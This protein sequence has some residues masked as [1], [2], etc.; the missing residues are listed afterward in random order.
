MCRSA[1]TKNSRLGYNRAVVVIDMSTDRSQPPDPIGADGTR[2]HLIMGAYCFCVCLFTF[3][4]S[5]VVHI[6]VGPRSPLPLY[7]NMQT[8][9]PIVD[10]K[11]D[12][13]N[14]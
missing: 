1:T 2:W 8:I 11:D 13:F 4:E 9:L 10:N 7:Y 14:F 12:L 5:C 6:V 3:G